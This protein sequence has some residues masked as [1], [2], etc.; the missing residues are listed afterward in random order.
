MVA[1]PPH[2]LELSERLEQLRALAD[3]L[4][5]GVAEAAQQHGARGIDTEEDLIEANKRWSSVRLENNTPPQVA[6]TH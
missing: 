5:I 2:P 1:L 4:A 3:G 6:G